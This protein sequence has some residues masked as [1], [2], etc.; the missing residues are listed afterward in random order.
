MEFKQS[1]LLNVEF[2][3][4]K[5]KF[6]CRKIEVGNIIESV[7]PTERRK[8]KKIQEEKRNTISSTEVVT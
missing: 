8:P 6:D 5:F 7:A 3:F 4:C 1:L 2:T